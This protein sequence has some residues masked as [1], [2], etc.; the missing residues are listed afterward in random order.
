[1]G[2]SDGDPPPFPLAY[3]APGRTPVA[4]IILALCSEQ[5]TSITETRMLEGGT[6]IVLARPDLLPPLGQLEFPVTPMPR[7]EG[8]AYW[9]PLPQLPVTLI[10]ATVPRFQGAESSNATRRCQ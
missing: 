6:D 10:G 9:P 1:M 3:C 5:V 4:E 2:D 7:W 8:P